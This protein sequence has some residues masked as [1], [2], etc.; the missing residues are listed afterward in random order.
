[1]QKALNIFV[2]RLY[3]DLFDVSFR[4]LSSPISIAVFFALQGIS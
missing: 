1:M 2:H 3:L 4:C